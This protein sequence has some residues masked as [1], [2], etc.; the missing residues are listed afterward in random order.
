M[1]HR[2]NKRIK[3]TDYKNK[4]VLKRKVMSAENLDLLLHEYILNTFE[5]SF[6]Y[7][8]PILNCNNNNDCSFDKF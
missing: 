8:A 6:K 7:N 1:Y 4:E 3:H 2:Y 5:N